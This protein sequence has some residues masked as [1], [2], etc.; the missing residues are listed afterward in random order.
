MDG[1]GRMGSTVT[2]DDPDDEAPHMTR[3]TKVGLLIGTLILLLVGIVVSDHLAVKRESEQLASGNAGIQPGVMPVDPLQSGRLADSGDSPGTVNGGVVTPGVND[4]PG[5][6]GGGPVIPTFNELDQNLQAILNGRRVG[7]SGL[8][9]TP[10]GVPGTVPGAGSVDG[11]NNQTH[12]GPGSGSTDIGNGNRSGVT[13]LEDIDRGAGGDTSTTNVRPVFHYVKDGETLW[14]IA[15]QYY[16][17]GSKWALIAKHNRDR[18]LAGN[19]V[20]EGIRL[21]IPNRIVE[22]ARNGG[23]AAA[24]NTTQT[25]NP[26]AGSAGRT[27]TVK[28]GDNLTRIAQEHLGSVKHVGLILKAN[29]DK[30]RNAN[31]IRVGM[32]L[33]LP[34]VPGPATSRSGAQPGTH[35]GTQLGTRSGVQADNVIRH[36]ANLVR[37]GAVNRTGV[38]HGSPRNESTASARRTYTVQDG[39]T[40][41]SVAAEALGSGSRW[42]EVWKLNKSRIPNPN[43]LTKGLALQLPAR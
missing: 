5:A 43:V 8:P 35:T 22:V 6:A 41:S 23:N 26:T 37:N 2:D 24:G 20:R 38:T 33:H 42:Q 3:E 11:T 9:G 25:G 21:Q 14:A 34:V 15:Q 19:N 40:L 36:G 13:N 39:D 7:N 10:M 18:L 17:D 12:H 16:G 27:I 28:S 4:A 1:A 32:K 29:R 31:Q 30:I